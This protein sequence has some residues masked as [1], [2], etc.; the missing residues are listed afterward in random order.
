MGSQHDFS[1]LSLHRKIIVSYP[2]F[3]ALE[4]NA[5][6]YQ[7]PLFMDYFDIP[8]IAALV[9]RNDSVNHPRRI[10]PTDY[11]AELKVA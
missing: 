9:F 3:I 4:N 7:P 8:R 10:F 5:F 1:S 2:S 6:G 11:V